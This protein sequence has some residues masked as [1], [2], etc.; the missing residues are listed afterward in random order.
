MPSLADQAREHMAEFQRQK[1]LQR[2]AK[3]INTSVAA[4]F[5]GLTSAL[6]GYTYGSMGQENPTPIKGLSAM[7]GAL[8]GYQTLPSPNKK[9]KLLSAL[10]GTTLSL[11]G[12]TAGNK[13]GL[14]RYQA[15]Q[16]NLPTLEK[17][18][19]RKALKALALPTA[20]VTS[21]AMGALAHRALAVDASK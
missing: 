3:I 15:K 10:A 18:K 17:D 13:I 11:A 20:A 8:S 4:G 5:H 6:P 12:D 2:Q 21:A 19:T 16:D 9:Y 14:L 7:S 1:D